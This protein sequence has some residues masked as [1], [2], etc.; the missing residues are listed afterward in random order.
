MG[1]LLGGL[2]G[3]AFRQG[4]DRGS[5]GCWRCGGDLFGGIKRLCGRETEA[6]GEAKQRV[7]S[8]GA[9]DGVVIPHTHGQLNLADLLA[10]EGERRT[11]V[12][13]G[14][15]TNAAGGDEHAVVAGVGIAIDS[16]PREQDGIA[17]S[18]DVGVG[19]G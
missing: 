13:E 16:R 4:F 12:V 5:Y 1:Q 19:I 3:C 17:E 8:I 18:T 9:V 15:E 10:R 11:Q 7:G 6:G 2:K 14:R